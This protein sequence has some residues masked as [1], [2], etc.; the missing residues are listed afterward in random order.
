MHVVPSLS[1]V[2]DIILTFFIHSFGMTVKD[3][4]SGIKM[5]DSF[6]SILS[7]LVLCPC[8]LYRVK[9]IS[10][11]KIEVFSSFTYKFT[12]LL[13][14]PIYLKHGNDSVYVTFVDKYIAVFF[15][16]GCKCGEVSLIMEAS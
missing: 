13:K 8:P 11:Y 9:D 6:H 1:I 16:N 5:S 10:A 12:H 4:Q 15:S 3:S 2:C 7:L 14:V